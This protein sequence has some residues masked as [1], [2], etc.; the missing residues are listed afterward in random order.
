V[1]PPEEADAVGQTSTAADNTMDE[2]P[3]PLS[4]AAA[5]A[6]TGDAEAAPAPGGDA[7]A[8]TEGAGTAQVQPQP[9]A[10]ED[11]DT[12]AAGAAQPILA[13]PGEAR[14][15]DARLEFSFTED[16]WLEVRDGDNQLIYADLHGEGE[17]LVVEGKPPFQVLAGNA[18]AL[19][20]SY[21]GEP[22][23][24]QTRPGRDTARF[25]VGEP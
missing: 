14:P 21:Q 18:A 7:T 6:V 22:Y 1:N 20:L 12:A 8:R 25:T 10:R 5:S 13:R 19:T 23:P 15:G 9:V 17:V 24:V 11:T 2:A 3:E 16:C 4:G